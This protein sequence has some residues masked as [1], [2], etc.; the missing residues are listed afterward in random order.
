MR[1]EAAPSVAQEVKRGP[2]NE[3]LVFVI[4]RE[5]MSCF[6]KRAAYPR[7]KEFQE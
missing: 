2:C 3:H 7:N 4:R 5:K 1:G 6:R